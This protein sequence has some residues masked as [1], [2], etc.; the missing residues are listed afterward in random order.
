MNMMKAS[1]VH[2]VGA[3]IQKS[4]QRALQADGITPLKVVGEVHLQLNRGDHNLTLD[5]LVVEDLDVD[6]LAGTPF[7]TQH[8]ISVRPAMCQVIIKDNDVIQYDSSSTT[9]HS[10]AVRRTQAY[11][12]RAPSF[13]TTVWPGDYLELTLPGELHSEE[14][15]AL[16]ARY[17]T[18]APKMST[19]IWPQ[20][21]LTEQ[22]GGKIRIAND[23]DQPQTLKRHEHFCQVRRVQTIT[24]TDNLAY[25]P[26]KPVLS[27]VL[28]DTTF[29]S[30][31][32]KLDPDYILPQSVRRDFQSVMQEFDSVFDPTITG[33]NGS[34]G[35]FQAIVNKGSVEPPQRK[36]R[37]P[38]YSKDKLQELQDI[39]D[40][41][42]SKLPQPV[43]EQSTQ[44]SPQ[45]IGISFAADVLKGCKQLIFLL[46]ETD[47]VR[48]DS[49]PG[50]VALRED[51]ALLQLGITLDMGRIK[52]PNKNPVAEKAI[53]E[54]ID[55]IVRYQP[56]GG[57]VTPLGLSIVASNLNSRLRNRG[58]SSREIWTQRCQFDN[59]QL[60][61]CDRDLIL[62]Q[63]ES[64]LRN[65]P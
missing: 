40:Q 50:F 45:S 57:S 30:D 33:Y 54:L 7:M 14:I 28:K 59:T 25:P 63:Y 4:I 9:T 10:S 21:S 32:V 19:K 64:R 49:A 16:E 56:E 42:E 18:G 44:P 41:L 62:Q 11:V 36:G 48:V 5:A 39:F 65:H 12:L 37:I 46:R 51:S 34:V 47:F 20:P 6:V 3:P 52:N 29:F 55:E 61:I 38:Q 53:A 24:D 13:S 8:D 27:A 31:I 43:A 26:A 15:L 2:Y 35:P 1:V 23:T 22:V 58:L 17:D 60:P